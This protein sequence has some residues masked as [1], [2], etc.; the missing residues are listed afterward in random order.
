MNKK[1]I[2]QKQIR[3]WDNAINDGSGIINGLYFWLRKR[4][5]EIQLE[6]MR[7]NG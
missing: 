4:S 3:F 5:C 7:A 2:I 6:E 1:A